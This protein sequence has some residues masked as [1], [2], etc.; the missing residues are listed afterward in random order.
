MLIPLKEARERLARAR[1]RPPEIF[2]LPVLQ[3]IGKLSA[4][5]VA[6]RV[7]LPPSEVSAMDGY[8]L[9]VGASPSAGPFRVRGATYPSSERLRWTLRVG[10]ASYITTGATLPKG[11]NSVV[12]VE[13]TLRKGDALYLRH[14][15]EVGQDVVERG[16]S[17]RRGDALLERGEAISAIHVGAL[18]AQRVRQ[19]PTYRV[20]VT[21]LP[22]GDELVAPGTLSSRGV[23]DFIGPTLAG[24]LGFAEVKL[25]GPV[26]DDR[27]L[28]ARTLSHAA[29]HSDLVLTIG[30]SSA[31]NKDVTKAA[32]AEVGTQLFEGVTTNVLKRGGVG[33]VSRVPVVVLPGQLVSAIAVFH[34]HAL[35]VLSRMAGRELRVFEEV[36]LAEDLYVGHR[37]DST[38]L[39]RVLA[40]HASPL[41]WGVARLTAMLRAQAFGILTHGQRHR[42]GEKIRVQRLWL[43][44]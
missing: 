11:A 31:G 14:A 36:R 23:P 2:R 38:Y 25:L 7:D 12:R 29:R 20:R 43:L 40:G 18:I 30:G 15:A 6:A 21:I 24:L 34:E 4:A 17:M 28:V 5:S 39:F 19:M 27:R 8:A 13:A 26:A 37:M 33:V 1:F 3:S 16:E 35:H 42:A 41:P 32:L 10:E 44:R 22:I 9:R